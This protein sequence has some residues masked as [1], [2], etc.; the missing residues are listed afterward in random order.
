MKG[1]E[2]GK[3][4]SARSLAS[5]PETVTKY[6]EAIGLD[7]TSLGRQLCAHYPGTIE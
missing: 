5:K 3:C 6:R 2:S 1:P 4:W 7:M